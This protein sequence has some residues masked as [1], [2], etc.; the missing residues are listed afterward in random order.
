M[1]STKNIFILAILAL[2]IGCSS[3]TTSNKSEAGSSKELSC[4]LTSPELQKRKE[5]VLEVIKKEILER[6]E[7]PDGYSYKFNGNDSI[8]SQL[9]D[10]IRSERM[11]CDFFT[12]TLKVQDEK[13]FIW[14]DITGPDGVKAILRDEAGL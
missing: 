12:F 10:F 11:C 8:Y 1:K 9:T 6:K 5:T 3:V 4:K 2:F 13:S 7:L 14:M